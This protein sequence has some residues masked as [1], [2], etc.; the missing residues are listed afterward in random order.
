MHERVIINNYS[1]AKQNSYVSLDLFNLFG[2][3]V[4]INKLL[5]LQAAELWEKIVMATENVT[6]EL[7]IWLRII[8]LLE[9]VS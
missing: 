7:N 9:K 1:F 2:I 8:K 5:T 3:N 6:E 4:I